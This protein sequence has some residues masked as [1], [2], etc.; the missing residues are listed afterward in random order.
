M[1]GH[2]PGHLGPPPQLY[3]ELWVENERLREQLQE[4]ELK[5]TQIKLELERVTQV[6]LGGGVPGVPQ[7]WEVHTPPPHFTPC[8]P[9]SA[10]K[11]SRSGQRC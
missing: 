10:R 4:T 6:S 2:P 11:G 7:V 3:E 8:P 9:H 1:P 5:L